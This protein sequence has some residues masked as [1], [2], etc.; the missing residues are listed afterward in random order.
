[1]ELQYDNRRKY[2]DQV[3]P[4]SGQWATSGPRQLV[5]RFA[6]IICQFVKN[7]YKF[8]YFLYPEIFEKKKFVI[9]I[10]SAA[11]SICYRFKTL[12]LKM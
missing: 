9:I 7:Y 8:I 3:S 2:L 4:T 5:I 12:P 6:L 11:L 1:M 10:S